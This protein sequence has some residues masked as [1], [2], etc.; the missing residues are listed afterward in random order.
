M[1]KFW[2]GSV[3][4]FQDNFK[5]WRKGEITRIN[6][7]SFYIRPGRVI[8]SLMRTDTVYFPIQ[9]YKIDDIYAMPKKGVLVSYQNGSY[10]MSRAGG[11]VHWYW[12]KS[13]F[14]FRVGGAGLVVLSIVNNNPAGIGVGAAIFAVGVLMNKIYKPYV[15]MG[16]SYHF[17]TVRLDN[18]PLYH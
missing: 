11:H 1:E 14:L 8:Y 3:I 17:E 4:S 16:R 6:N 7:D 5:Q 13:G 18:K 12:V 9:G 10:Q 2:V 15:R